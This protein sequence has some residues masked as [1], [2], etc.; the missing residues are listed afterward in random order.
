MKVLWAECYKYY[1]TDDP[2]GER[3]LILD[4]EL[5]DDT[6]AG[7]VQIASFSTSTPPRQR[8]IWPDE[9]KRIGG[10]RPFLRALGELRALDAIVA[11]THKWGPARIVVDQ[12]LFGVDSIAHTFS[13]VGSPVLISLNMGSARVRTLLLNVMHRNPIGLAAITDLMLHERAHICLRGR[14][15]KHDELFYAE[16]QR[17]KERLLKAL[18]YNR[19][20]DPFRLPWRQH[21]ELPSIEELRKHLPHKDVSNVPVKYTS[22]GLPVIQ[23]DPRAR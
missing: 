17:L 19:N 15:N 10:F 8:W 13:T 5:L 16:K 22:E 18:A 20:L 21:V 3:S 11:R 4:T 1:H 12:Y 9:L 2:R 7:G 14:T 23:L 6:T